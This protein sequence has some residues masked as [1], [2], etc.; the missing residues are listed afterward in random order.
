MGADTVKIFCPKCQCV[1]H[2]PP[3]RYRNSQGASSSAAVDGAA[4]GTTF[5]HLFLLTFNNLVPD[6]LL[7]ESSY[8]PRVFGFRVHPSS[9]QRNVSSANPVIPKRN[10]D[11]STLD[12]NDRE[13]VLIDQMQQEHEINN[14]G[15]FTKQ[16]P[17]SVGSASNDQSTSTNQKSGKK[18]GR[19][20]K[21][22]DSSKKKDKGG[23]SESISS[24]SKRFKIPS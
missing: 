12:Q 1:Y 11:I 13:D 6:E 17:V 16:P 15:T 21:G 20:P 4:F 19:K 10:V 2:P 7:P 23:D 9:R 8:I 22:D 14:N 5:P 3:L 24:K 18:R